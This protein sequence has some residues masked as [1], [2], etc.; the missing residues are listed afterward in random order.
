MTTDTETPSTHVAQMAAEFMDYLDQEAEPG[1]QVAAAVVA[2]WTSDGAMY[3]RVH[4][5]PEDDPGDGKDLA[6]LAISLA[7]AA[8]DEVCD[9]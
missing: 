3:W 6:R 4:T 1:A 5:E 7:D 2:V 8:L 9:A